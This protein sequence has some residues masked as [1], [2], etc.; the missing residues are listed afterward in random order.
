MTT[1]LSPAVARGYSWRLPPAPASSRP[2]N[3]STPTNANSRIYI[4]SLSCNVGGSTGYVLGSTQGRS[5]CVFLTKDG[6][7]ERL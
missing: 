5:S 3:S 1:D 6:T 2:R 7:R 4:G